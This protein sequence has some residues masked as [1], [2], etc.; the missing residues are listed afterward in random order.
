MSFFAKKKEN[1]SWPFYSPDKISL[2]VSAWTIHLT[3]G[4]MGN[5]VARTHAH[6]RSLTIRKRRKKG[7]ATKSGEVTKNT[8]MPLYNVSVTLLS[9]PRIIQEDCVTFA[10]FLILTRMFHWACKHVAEFAGT[11]S[12]NENYILLSRPIAQQQKR[13]S[14]LSNWTTFKERERES[15]RGSRPIDPMTSPRLLG[16]AEARSLEWALMCKRESLMMKTYPDG[17]T[18]LAEMRERES[19]LHDVCLALKMLDLWRLSALIFERQRGINVR[20]KCF[21]SLSLPSSSNHVCPKEER[22]SV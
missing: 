8:R 1:K 15:G 5:N 9:K 2:L 4:K 16:R 11:S 6:T 13:D 20:Q 22:E 17:V 21:F 14:V 12:T 7:Q 18:R 19:I 10:P 3:A